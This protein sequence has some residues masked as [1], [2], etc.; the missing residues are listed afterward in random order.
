V[1]HFSDQPLISAAVGS[2]GTYLFALLVGI[3]LA[4]AA[5]VVVQMRDPRRW[6]IGVMGAVALWFVVF[7]PDVSGLPIPS[8]LKNLFQVLPLPT[9]NYDFQFATNVAAEPVGG[10]RVIT[11]GSLTLMLGVTLLT[12]AVM[13]AAWNWR[14]ARVLRRES[15]GEG[16]D[17]ATP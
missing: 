6:V 16:L 8:G 9:Y 11:P 5:W 12:V 1:Q 17:T 4:G 15:A 13:Y 10:V 14:L 3:P 2:G 7:Y